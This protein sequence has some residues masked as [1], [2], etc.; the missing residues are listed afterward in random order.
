MQ[1]I[2]YAITL[3]DSCTYIL[4]RMMQCNLIGRCGGGGG[5]GGGGGHTMGN[6]SENQINL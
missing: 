2:K 4:D 1:L 6:V 5:G 3:F